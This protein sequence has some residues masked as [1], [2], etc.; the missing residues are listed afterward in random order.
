MAPYLHETTP[1]VPNFLIIG[2][3]KAGT[4]SLYHYLRSHPEVFMPAVKE[5]D[6]FVEDINWRRG[7]S[8][9]RRQ[10]ASAPPEARAVGEASTNY[11]KYPI[12]SRVPEKIAR[13]L[14]SARLIYVVRHPVER[15]RSQYQHSTAIGREQRP[16]E[17][18]VLGDPRYITCS[19]YAFQIEQYMEQFDPEQL[20]IVTAE[21]LRSHRAETVRRVFAF[22]GIDPTYEVPE[23]GRE[24]LKTEGRPRYPR[25]VGAVRR[26]LKHH[27][28]QSKQAKEFVDAVR[29]R[30]IGGTQSQEEGGR[31]RAAR[32]TTIGSITIPDHVRRRIEDLIRD[33]VTRLHAYM[34]PSFDGWGIG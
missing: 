33:D 21:D 6:F 28:P 32:V 8:W 19:R 11:S 20:L 16:F 2:A 27:L 1:T 4:T 12:H 15:I 5:L 34:P 10:F 31:H 25:A 3:M 24:F 17:E 18:A 22:L 23:L 9:Y 30:R 14:P 29:T 26:A 13:H 7:L